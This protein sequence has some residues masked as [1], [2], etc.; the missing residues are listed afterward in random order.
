MSYESFVLGPLH[1]QWYGLIMTGA[2]LICILACYFQSL[3][4]RL[5]TTPLFDIIVLSIP[6]GLIGAHFYYVAI[7]WPYY[8]Y[9]LMEIFCFTQGGLAMHGA[10]ISVA[11]VLLVYCK[12]KQLSFGKYADAIAPGLALG[13]ALGQ[14]ANLVNQEAIG[15]PADVLGGIY[16]DYALRPVGYE[17]YDFFHPIFMYQSS[18]D[19]VVFLILLTASWLLRKKTKLVPGWLFFVYLIL[20]SVGRMVVESIR[21]DSEILYGVNVAQLGSLIIIIIAGVALIV[22]QKRCKSC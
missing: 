12:Y 3:Y 8:G 2:I 13:Q 6:A 7:N 11:V 9:H 16:I 5:P 1:F 19:F 14:W 22:R 4:K 21:L 17:G 15:Y 20:Q 18:A 10:M